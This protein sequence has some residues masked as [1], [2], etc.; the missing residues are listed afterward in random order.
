MY[1]GM[2]PNFTVAKYCNSDH[3]APH[4][5]SVLESYTGEEVGEMYEQY[6]GIAPAS[7][8]RK[9]KKQIVFDRKIAM[10]LYLNKGWDESKGGQLVDLETDDQILPMHN[11]LVLFRVPRMH[12]VLPVIGNHERLSIFGWWLTEKR[13]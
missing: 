2:L 13:A 12:C 3:I 11:T 8:L 6:G 4:D 5:D 10:I 1:P 7:H 9:R